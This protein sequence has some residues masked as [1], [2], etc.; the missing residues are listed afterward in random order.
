MDVNYLWL[1]TAF[2]VYIYTD[3]IMRL[4]FLISVEVKTFAIN[5]KMFV[6]AYRIHRKLKSDMRAM[7]LKCPPFRFTPI[8]LRT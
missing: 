8:W 6:M 2:L 3:D 5:V 1:I 7:G 4:A